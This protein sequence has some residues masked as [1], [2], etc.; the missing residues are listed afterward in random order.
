MLFEVHA[1]T[2]HLLRLRRMF[3]VEHL[4]VFFRELIG[5]RLARINADTKVIGLGCRTAFAL[6]GGDAT[7]FATGGSQRRLGFKLRSIIG[8]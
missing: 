8:V 6:F 5:Q 3:T 1:V 2:E 4:K 7:A